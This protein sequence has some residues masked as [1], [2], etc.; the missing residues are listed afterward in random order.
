MY[1]FIFTVF[2]SPSNEAKVI[3]PMIEKIEST[4]RSSKRVYA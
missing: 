2:C 1:S 4:I 3:P